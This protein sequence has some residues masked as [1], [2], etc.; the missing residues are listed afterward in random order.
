[1]AIEDI[2]ARIESDAAREIEKAKAA[3]ESQK[4]AII[5]EA[6]A[7]ADAIIAA[8]T[9][10]A[11][12]HKARTKERLVSA[13]RLEAR[14]RLLA[15]KQKLINLAFER[16]LENVQ[17]LHDDKYRKLLAALLVK[18]VDRGDES[19]VVSERDAVRL[20]EGFIEEV[21]KEIEHAKS[22]FG[23]TRK[24][25]LK[26]V[27]QKAETGGGFVLRSGRLEVNLTFPA[28]LKAI[29][30]RIEADVAGALFG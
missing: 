8:A 11:K 1:M 20:G 14:D 26:I 2:L 25:H 23:K 4:A 12:Q 9:Q 16:A 6:Q 17:K 5:A 3:S 27:T 22:A 18:H 10:E 30:D 13:A 28:M 21:N 19:V 29:R 7:A 24:G 15:E